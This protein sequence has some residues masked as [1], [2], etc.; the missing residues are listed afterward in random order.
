MVGPFPEI[1][2][3]ENG[4]NSGEE[5]KSCVLEISYMNY[6]LDNHMEMSAGKL[7][8]QAW[9][10]TGFSAESYNFGSHEHTNN[11]LS[12]GIK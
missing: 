7:A 3:T 8:R 4:K 2:K 5:T 11:I 10:F 1:K 12:F 9:C 6:L